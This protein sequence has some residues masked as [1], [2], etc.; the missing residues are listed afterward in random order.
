MKTK[1]TVIACDGKNAKVRVIRE[2]A[3]EGC[4][5]CNASGSCG[6]EIVIAQMPN[7]YDLDVSNTVG[8]KKGDIVEI[9]PGTKLSLLFAFIV[10]ILPIAAAVIAYCFT[11]ESFSANISVLISVGMFIFSFLICAFIADKISKSADKS[12]ICK[13]IKESG[14]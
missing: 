9:M 3:C 8:A 10:F 13:I 7:T 6:A 14:L 11:S 4:H 12:S 1:A 5:G 2:S